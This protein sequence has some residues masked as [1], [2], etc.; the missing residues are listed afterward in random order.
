VTYFFDA[1]HEKVKLPKLLFTDVKQN[2]F[3]FT[4]EVHFVYYKA[5]YADFNADVA[6]GLAGDANAL[7]IVGI[8]IVARNHARN[9][10]AIK[11]RNH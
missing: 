8:F 2:I 4:N 9:S 7:A 3:R 11:V 1:Y 10:S 6:G 5:S